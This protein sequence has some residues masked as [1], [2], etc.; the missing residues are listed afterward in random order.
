MPLK[1][2]LFKLLPLE[3][4]INAPASW[5]TN[6]PGAKSCHFE[7][8]LKFTY[9]SIPPWASQQRPVFSSDK[10]LSLYVFLPISDSLL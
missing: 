9:A 5:A 8:L 7:G 6:K 1:K 4:V 2:F 10:D 3:S